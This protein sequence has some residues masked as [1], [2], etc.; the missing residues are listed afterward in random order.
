MSLITRL[1]GPRP[2]TPQQS[3][4]VPSVVT[5]ST[6]ETMPTDLFVDNNAPVSE[7]ASPEQINIVGDF[8]DQDFFN[9]GAR[10]AFNFHSNELLESRKKEIKSQFNYHLDRAIQEKR[11]KRLQ[12]ENL[13]VEMSPVSGEL[14]DKLVNSI[15][16]LDHSLELLQQQKE[17][18]ALDE[19]WVMSPVRKYHTGFLQGMH[20]YLD[21]EKL[22]LSSNIF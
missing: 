20:D 6:E 5:P 17:L 21:T 15:N 19:G 8:L 14:K 7:S 4:V 10:D 2:K 13:F 1:F 12:L 16:E 3:D 9:L 11:T 22:L 18:A